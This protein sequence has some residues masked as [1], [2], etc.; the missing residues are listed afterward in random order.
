MHSL[1]VGSTRTK[2][3]VSVASVSSGHTPHAS[4]ADIARHAAALQTQQQGQQQHAVYREQLQYR[5]NTPANNKESVSSYDSNDYFYNPDL[6][7]SFPPVQFH[8]EYQEEQTQSSHSNNNTVNIAENN[9]SQ[10]Q[11]TETTAASDNISDKKNKPSHS[12]CR[13][14]LRQNKSDSSLSVPPVVILQK[15]Q[16]DVES[17][18]FTFGFEVSFSFLVQDSAATDFFCS[19]QRVSVSHELRE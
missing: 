7:S 16:T 8:S 1:P 12:N 6:D 17:S 13:S 3:S 2:V 5:E 14:Q 18:G 19:G 9:N 4:Y 10:S 11:V 15:H